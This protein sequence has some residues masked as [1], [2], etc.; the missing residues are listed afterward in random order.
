MRVA[1]QVHVRLLQRRLQRLERLLGRLER[2][3]EL[4]LV[5]LVQRRQ[6]HV[7]YRLG[8]GRPVGG[9]ILR[10]RRNQQRR[11]L[12]LRKQI[13]G[14]RT[15]G[16][17]LQA[18][19]DACDS[20]LIYCRQQL[21]RYQY[22]F[23]GLGIVEEHDGLEVIAQCN[24]P[25]VEVDDLRHGTIGV[26]TEAEPDACAAQVVAI[27]GLRHFDLAAKPHRVF[28]GRQPVVTIAVCIHL[29]PTAVVE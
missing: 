23:A 8:K 21:H 10:Q 5:L 15:I 17:E 11:S 25:A 16:R 20:L 19:I 4:L 7:T 13:S 29:L 24:A 26:G 3:I 6:I 18:Q 1:G 27:Q 9:D 2:S 28:R 14:I 22:L 12:K